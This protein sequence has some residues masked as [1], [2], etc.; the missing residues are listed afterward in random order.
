ME[1]Y[2]EQYNQK[3][4]QHRETNREQ[5][6]K[7]QKQYREANREKLLKKYVCECGCEGLIKHR[8]RHIKTKKHL[9]YLNKSVRQYIDGDYTTND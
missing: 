3:Q 6:N 2:R 8:N 5:Y 1:A 4:K 7:T 9:E